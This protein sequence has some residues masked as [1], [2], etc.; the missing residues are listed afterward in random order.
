MCDIALCKTSPNQVPHGKR[1]K[2]GFNQEVTA[3]SYAVTVLMWTVTAA[4]WGLS[5]IEWEVSSVARDAEVPMQAVAAICALN[6][7]LRPE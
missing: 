4:L 2:R 5:I 7:V 1:A 3:T 6:G